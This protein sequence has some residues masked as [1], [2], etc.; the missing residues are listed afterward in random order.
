MMTVA[1]AVILIEFIKDKERL[2]C[3]LAHEFGHFHS[4][5]RGTFP[6]EIIEKPHWSLTS[7]EQEEFIK[8][9]NRAWDDAELILQKLNYDSK[10]PCFQKL[11]EDGLQSYKESFL[12][13]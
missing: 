2:L 4:L 13:R 10:R 3:I 12:K 7:E 9:E 8:E 5:N 1:P 11:K 6:I